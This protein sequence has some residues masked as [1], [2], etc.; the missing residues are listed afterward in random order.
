MPLDIKTLFIKDKEKNI[1][2]TIKIYKIN[3]KYNLMYF[4]NLFIFL[5]IF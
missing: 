3:Y 1:M 2:K 5:L 4:K